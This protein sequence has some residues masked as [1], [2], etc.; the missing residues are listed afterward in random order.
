[1]FVRC[2]CST[3]VVF[4][5]CAN[6][7]GADVSVSSHH[8]YKDIPLSVPVQVDPGMIGKSGWM[9]GPDGTKIPAQITKPKLLSA[10]SDAHSKHNAE[11]NFVLPE[12]KDESITLKPDFDGAK[13]TA[14]F[15]WSEPN[16]KFHELSLGDRPVLRYMHE[17]LDTS[18]PERIG[19]TYKVY[20]HVYNPAGTRYV[21][22][23]PGG[24]FPHH[25]G[26]FYGFNKI[27]YGDVTADI[28]H[29]RKGENQDHVDFT[30]VE[31]GSVLGRHRLAI[32][33]NGKDG[34]AFA[35]EMRELTVYNL[36][37]GNLIEFASILKTDLPKVMLAGDPQHAGFQFRASQY[38]PDNTADKT[39]YLRPDGKGEPGKFR[40]W[41]GNK[42]H[43]NLRWNTLNFVIDDQHYA[44]CYLD[45]PNNPKEARFSERD[46]GRFGSYFEYELTPDSP[47][48]LNYR[49]WL[50]EGEMTVE[51]AS[52]L[53]LNFTHPPEVTHN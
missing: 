9:V 16:D 40:N 27:S 36:P 26:L 43:V 19:E 29:C 13:E 23:G 42:D 22:K 5:L 25:R 2:Y 35:K 17:Q 32:D 7:F 1:M 46:Y 52:A 8:H 15:Q 10:S 20:H 38:V 45:R 12:I 50:Q 18:T 31:G 30:N 24:K 34:K 48:R 6:L 11:Y 47:L 37:G 53:H 3:A 44:C 14:T 39:F 28:W 41:P 4:A 51:Q 21:T 49:I 33:W